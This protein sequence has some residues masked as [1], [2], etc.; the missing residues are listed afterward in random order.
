MT[1]ERWNIEDINHIA[2]CKRFFGEACPTT[3][4]MAFEKSLQS[5]KTIGAATGTPCVRPQRKTSL[6]GRQFL[7]GFL[8]KR[9]WN[10]GEADGASPWLL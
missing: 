7:P 10:E 2:K 3:N 8:Q 4:T 1:F 6:E 9:L 5:T